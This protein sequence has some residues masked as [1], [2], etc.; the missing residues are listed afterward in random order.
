MATVTDA[1]LTYAEVGATAGE[2]PP[3]YNHLRRTVVLGH[4]LETFARA[5]RAVMTWELHRR[6]G[7]IVDSDSPVA[8]LGTDVR[9]GWSVGLVHVKVSCRVVRVTDE[10]NACGFAYGTLP[11]H[12]EQGEESFTIRLKPTGAVMLEIVA[13]SR[14]SLWWARM[15]APVS[16]LVQRRI[17]ARYLDALVEH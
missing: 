17:T 13:F 7:L 12:P 3:G 15:G 16:R 1:G 14:P 10:A 11:G 9:L 2:L 4:G 6:A 5:S 8:A